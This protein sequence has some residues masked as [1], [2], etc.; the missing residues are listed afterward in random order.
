MKQISLS[1][2]QIDTIV[3]SNLTR[4]EIK[5]YLGISWPTIKVVCKKYNI[6]PNAERRTYKPNDNYFKIW[7]EEMAYFLGLIAADGHVRKQ[8]NFL[9]LS[10][11][12]TDE[13]I[14]EN[15]KE[16]LQYDGPLYTINKKDGQTQCCLT[17]CSKEIV[18]D[19][20]NLGLSGNKTFDFDWIN[21]MEDKYV[22]HF[23]RGMFDGDGCIYINEKKGNFETTIIGTDKLTENIKNKYDLFSKKYS[24]HLAKRGKVQ[25]LDF[26]GKYNALAFLDWIY[27]DS[28][29]FTRLERKY[30]LYLKLKNTICEEEKP[31]NNARIN[32][33]TANKI[34]EIYS[35]GLNVKEISNQLDISE[36]IIHDV[37]QNRTWSDLNYA[38]EKKKQDII[39]ITYNN[40]TQSIREWSNE[41]GIP[42]STIDR[43]YRN[44]LPIDQVMSIE[45]LPK[46][47]TKQSEKDKNAHAL[48]RDIR[49]DYQNGLKGK[50]LFEKHNVPKSRAMDILANRT[51][52]EENVWWR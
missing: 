21:G 31:N 26:N 37:V 20:N 38:P 3:N 10:L 7:S 14:I 11:K 29:Q 9:M 18:T 23:V 51:C 44:N 48:A 41:L 32:Q 39:S 42:Y 16:A 47:K 50:L 35:T 19:L 13:K 24:G 52:K 36:S 28:T 46:T 49:L 43:R 5:E 33:D 45:E 30:E 12:K 17:V 22:S 15:L 1:Q 27:T 34:R 4:S 40:K 8:N 2:S 25:S 6:V